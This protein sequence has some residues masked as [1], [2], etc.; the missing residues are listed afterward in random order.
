MYYD[1]GD[2]HVFVGVGESAD[3]GERHLTPPSRT[4]PASSQRGVAGEGG[5]GGG[6]WSVDGPAMKP[7]DK[8]ARIGVGARVQPARVGHE[9]RAVAWEKYRVAERYSDRT[10]SC[11]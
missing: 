1:L 11:R 2:H 3:S 8:G 9:S 4:A 5:A 6:S 10:D 7:L